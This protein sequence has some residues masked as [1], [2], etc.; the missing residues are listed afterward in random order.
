MWLLATSCALLKWFA[1]FVQSSRFH[2]SFMRHIFIKHLLCASAVLAW[3]LWWCS[4]LTGYLPCWGLG[5]ELDTRSRQQ[6]TVLEALALHSTLVTAGGLKGGQFLLFAPSLSI[7]LSVP[8]PSSFFFFF[9]CLFPYSPYSSGFQPSRFQWDFHLRVQYC[10]SASAVWA[11]LSSTGGS[12]LCV[13][14]PRLGA[15]FLRRSESS[16]D[17]LFLTLDDFCKE[18]MFKLAKLCHFTILPMLCWRDLVATV[19][20]SVFRSQSWWNLYW[21]LNMVVP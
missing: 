9:S 6:T 21:N 4:K 1:P 19:Q 20:F 12:R 13:C 3:G 16:P 18:E 10:R 2:C 8:T 5:L 11:L 7:V 15:R 17:A 14:R